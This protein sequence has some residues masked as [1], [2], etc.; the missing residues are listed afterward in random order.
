MILLSNGCSTQKN[1]MLNRGYHSLNTKFNVLYNGNEAFNVGKSILEKANDDNFLEFLEV[2]P[3]L[4][5]GERIDQTSIV[6]GFDR[7]EEKA[8]KAIQKHSMNIKGFQRNNKIDNAYLLLLRM[9]LI[10]HRGRFWF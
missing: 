8:V 4:I 5:N 2:E 9:R 6:P 1:K 3:I 7:A 10:T